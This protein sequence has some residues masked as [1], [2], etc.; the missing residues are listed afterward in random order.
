MLFFPSLWSAPYTKILEGITWWDLDED[1][2]LYCNSDLMTFDAQY[3]LAG[4]FE[5]GNWGHTASFLGLDIAMCEGI[6]KVVFM[7]HDPV[8]SDQHIAEAAERARLCIKMQKEMT[9]KT[10]KKLFDVKWAYAYDGMEIE[11]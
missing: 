9:R 11:I 5:K 8:S 3:T 1:L 4:K 6:K 7:H 2:G 10:D